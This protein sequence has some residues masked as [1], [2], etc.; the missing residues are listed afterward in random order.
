MDEKSHACIMMGCS[1][2]SK[3]YWL[4]D[5]VKQQ[6]IINRNVIFDE[7]YLG[8]KLFNSSSSL[9][10]SDLF[11]IITD[12]GLTVPLL[13]I[14]FSQLTSIPKFIGSQC[15]TIETIT[16]IDW[17]LERSE[18]TLTPCLP[19]WVIKTLELARSNVGDISSSWVT[20][21]QR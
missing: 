19:R 17:I 9:L 11:D 14:L 16:F 12:N 2:E 5:L 6:I 20:H 7:K 15:T 3:S 4:F 10:H 18:N 1:K 8:I 21:N 13:S